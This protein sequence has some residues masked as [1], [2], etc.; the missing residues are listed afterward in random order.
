MEYLFAAETVAAAGFNPAE[1]VEFSEM[2]GRQDY[3]VAER[4]Q[5]GVASKYFD[6]GVLAPQDELIVDFMATYRAVMKD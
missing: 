3:D 6:H 2:V 5:R 1:I 4:V